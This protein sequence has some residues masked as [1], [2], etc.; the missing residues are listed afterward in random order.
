MTLHIRPAT[1]ADATA[2]SAVIIQSLQQSNAADYSAAL[3]AQVEQSFTP[4]RI[5]A[6][7]EQRQVLVAVLD[8]QVVA[9]ASLQGNVVRSVFVVPGLQG[10]GVGRALMQAI[11]DLAR[12]TGQALLRVPSSITAEAFYARLGYA[13]VREVME[14]EE[15]VI[16]ME[17]VF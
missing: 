8:Q 2:I 10:T 9:T 11:E 14:G 12:Q 4:E 1:P 5:L 17:R 7:L 13:K 3:I 6:L 15:R 16:V